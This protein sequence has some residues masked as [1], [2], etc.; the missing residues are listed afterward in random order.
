M[1]DEY[2]VSFFGNDDP[3]GDYDYEPERNIYLILHGFAANC[4]N[5][6]FITNSTKG[7]GMSVAEAAEEL[8]RVGKL[9]NFR[10]VLELDAYDGSYDKITD[11]QSDYYDEITICSRSSDNYREISDRLRYNNIIDHSDH[12]IFGP[13]DMTEKMKNAYLYAIKIGKK[14]GIMK[15]KE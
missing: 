1:N 3:G 4:R 13:G 6:M 14:I 9:E 5:V 10:V 7:F 8:R 11:M 2:V 12:I 15:N